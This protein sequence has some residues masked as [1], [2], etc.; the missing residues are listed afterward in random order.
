MLDQEYM[1]IQ[2]AALLAGALGY[3]AW[4]LMYC[5]TFWNQVTLDTLL[6][7]IV[8]TLGYNLAQNHMQKEALMLLL[9][10]WSTPF[11]HLARIAKDYKWALTSVGLLLLFAVVFISVR[12]LWGTYIMVT[13][14]VPELMES[15]IQFM[16]TSVVLAFMAL[17]FYWSALILKTI[18]KKIKPMCCK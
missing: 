14:V 13:Q 12:V 10:E 1:E 6:H 16:G 7:A 17:N 4:D 8:C 5:L 3:F 18:Y 2:Q 9:F 11:L 15:D